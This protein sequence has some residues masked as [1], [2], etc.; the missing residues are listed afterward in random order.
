MHDQLPPHEGRP[1]PASFQD[2][3][4]LEVLL[5]S[6][7]ETLEVMRGETI[8]DKARRWTQV[9]HAMTAL[10]PRT[11]YEWFVA[12]DVTTKQF[13][14]LHMLALY[15]RKGITA[16]TKRRRGLELVE[17]TQTMQDALSRYDTMRRRRAS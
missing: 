13:A 16:K 12:A 9:L 17:R 6:V 4:F 11:R 5:Y 1:D 3:R 2:N 8:V 15:Q 7:C 10:D 14:A